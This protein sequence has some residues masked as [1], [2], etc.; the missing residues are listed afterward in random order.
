MDKTF[1]MKKVC[2]NCKFWGVDYFGVCDEIQA[3]G[4]WLTTSAGS[5]AKILVS[6][7]DDQGLNAKLATQPDFGCTKFK[8][9]K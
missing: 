6:A 4:G 5:D 1:F 7:D 8:A 2:N 3:S 9:K